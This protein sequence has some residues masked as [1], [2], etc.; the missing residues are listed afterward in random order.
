MFIGCDFF[1]ISMVIRY[2]M[3]YFSKKDVK[4]IEKMFDVINEEIYLNW[5]VGDLYFFWKNFFFFDYDKFLV[6]VGEEELYFFVK[7]FLKC[8]LSLLLYLYYLYNFDF[9]SMGIFRIV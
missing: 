9:I 3:C 2:G 1:Y 8:F 6:F 5:F 4:K 7:E